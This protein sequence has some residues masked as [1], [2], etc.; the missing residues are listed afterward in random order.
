MLQE[1]KQ[2]MNRTTTENG[3]VSYQ[4]TMSHC[5]DL[6]ATAGALRA[7]SDHEIIARFLRAYIEDAD[8]AMR[9][10]FYA[11]D[12][13]GGLGERRFFRVALKFLC[14]NHPES[15][16][17]NLD[18]IAEMGRYDDFL[19]LLD[20]PCENAAVQYLK[21]QLERDL[22]VL[23]QGEHGISLLGKWLPSINTSNAETVRLG[24]KLARAFSM[25][26]RMYRKT[27]VKLRKEIDIIENHLREGNFDFD[28]AKQP[29]KAMFRYRNAFL[30]R[31]SERYRAFLNHVAQGVENLNTSTLVPYEIIRP[32]YV[33]N[34]PEDQC[35]V[36]DL[37]WKNQ[38]DLT[39]A[40]NAIAVIDIS[41]SMYGYGGLPAMVAHS[42][43][44]Y[45][46]ER[47]KGR[48]A[49]HFI[50]FSEKPQLIEIKGQTI[51]EKLQYL[52]SFNEVANTNVQAV[53][54]LMLETALKHKIPQEELPE[55]IFVISDMEF[56]ECVGGADMT[57]FEFAKRKFEE[58]GYRLPKIVFWNVASRALQ[59]PVTMN[60]NGVTL[61]SGCTP[62][63]FE[64]V[65]IDH[66]DP[67]DFMTEVI[68]SE[69]YRNIV[70]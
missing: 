31:D 33:S 10:L 32:F 20:T 22:A 60:E 52:S 18:F 4:T 61:V 14:K 8:L 19:V 30:N 35:E 36:I 27:L 43:G 44:I 34:V 15:V 42:L 39:D 9:I 59:L 49:N 46:A 1:L 62:K 11:R 66:T 41:G 54:E 50:T 65:V 2:E 68:M 47:N 55:R 57:N 58:A 21:T 63:L 48:F 6:F 26:E 23:E 16:S 13:R 70:A 51:L 12:I 28:Y 45:F 24:R 5:L 17:K 64:Q 3:A 56:D 69:R 25:T 37:T 38:A 29:S 67:Y 53:F 40:H 7:Q